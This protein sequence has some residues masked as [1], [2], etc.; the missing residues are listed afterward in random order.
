MRCTGVTR[1]VLLIAFAALA[2]LLS[3]DLVPRAHADAPYS[4]N[5]IPAFAQ[6]GSTIALVLTVSGATGNTLYVFR[7]FVRDPVGKTA[8]SPFQNY[9]TGLGQNQFNVR[10]YYP[11]P[12]FPGSNSLVGQY[13]TWVD[14]LGSVTQ[15]M[16]ASS[17]FVLSI[18]DNTGYERTQTVNMQAS[19]YNA[20]EMVTV[21]IRTQ[22]T[23]TLVL[24]Q[25]IPATSTG[26]VATSWK[27]PVNA[28]IDNYMLTLTGTSTVKSPP[29][30]QLFSI[31]PA[32][33]S[34]ASISSLQ[35]TYQ[36][37]ETMEFSFQPAYPDGSIASSGVGLLTLARPDR[38]NVTLTA[39]YDS[40]TQSFTTSYKTSADNQTGTWSATLTGHGYSD[41]Y[42]NSGPG[43]ILTSASQVT[44]AALMVNVVMDRTSYQVGEQIKFNATITYPDGTILQSGTM[45]AYLL[46][47]GTQTMNE[48]A[49]MV[50]D[51]AL[52][53]WIGTYTWTP[54]DAGGLWS[55]NVKAS[56]SS[57]PADTGSA[58]RAVSL[59]NSTANGNASFPLYYFGILAA[60]IAA[61]LVGAFLLFRRRRV[62]HASLKIDLEAVRSEAGKIE[63]QDFFKS[64]KGQLKKDQDD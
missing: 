8:Q 15:T 3:A 29:D 16:V 51:T 39:T 35:T 59:Q 47:S 42:G 44:P 9:T 54:G 53:V 13:V 14:Q 62:T 60:L 50:F 11:S 38:V 26:I 22:T 19:G 40:A 57:T 12:S 23:S 2:P 55:L 1:C 20:S 5:P 25:S 64:V 49:P 24:S 18:V 31:K 56:D 37:T 43:T 41:A 45:E 33:M 63:S 34:I 4:L 21:T 32:V 27:I 36:R 58:T 6:E 10:V 28:T 30:R 7:F 46:S 52:R 17:S 48:T 61:A